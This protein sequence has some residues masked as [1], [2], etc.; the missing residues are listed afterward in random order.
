MF[1]ARGHTVQIILGCLLN[2]A[3]AVCDC[4]LT[5]NS[6]QRLDLSIKSTVERQTPQHISWVANRRFLQAGIKY[7]DWCSV[8]RKGSRQGEPKIP[9]AARIQCKRRKQKSLEDDADDSETKVAGRWCWWFG[10]A[11][12]STCT[13]HWATLCAR[14]WRVKMTARLTPPRSTTTPPCS[15]TRQA[16]RCTPPWPGSRSSTPTAT[17]QSEGVRM[18]QT[19]WLF[20]LGCQASCCLCSFWFGFAFALFSHQV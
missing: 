20:A 5:L 15:A 11:A 8:S 1:E 13:T 14:W 16:W 9:A 18:T 17:F 12:C 4:S 10:F 7:K 19:W 3:V 2:W 6:S